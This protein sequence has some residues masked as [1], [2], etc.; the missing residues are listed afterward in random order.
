MGLFGSQR[1]IVSS[2][3]VNLGGAYDEIPGY[4]KTVLLGNII[5]PI[6]KPRAM[7]DL[8]KDA[9]L[10]GPGVKLRQFYRWAEDPLNYGQIGA[11]MA[12][13]RGVTLS[14]P[15]Q[16]FIN[17]YSKFD[18]TPVFPGFVAMEA[19]NANYF[20][21]A[22]RAALIGSQ[23]YIGG[24]PG[25]WPIPDIT[26][27]LLTGTNQIRATIVDNRLPSASTNYEGMSFTTSLSDFDPLARYLYVLYH[28]ADPGSDFSADAPRHMRIYIY[29]R[30]TGI[31]DFDARIPDAGDPVYEY[32]PTIPIRQRNVF[33]SNTNQASGK[34]IQKA[35]K[36]VFGQPV[37]NLEDRLNAHENIAEMDDVH[38]VFGVSADTTDK[39]CLEYLYRYF[40]Y[41]RYKQSGSLT[42]YNNFVTN[43]AAYR[44]A[45]TAWLA[46]NAG[47]RI[48]TA[49]TVPELPAST[50]SE[51]GIVTRSPGL[52][53]VFQQTISWRYIKEEFG[54]GL[55]K[56]T[57]KVGDL[58]FDTSGPIEQPTY[59]IRGIYNWGSGQT[60]DS[61]AVRLYWQE[62]STSWR[63][64]TLA[65]MSHRN[66]IFGSDSTY[67]T[68]REAL[69]NPN[70]SG[71]LVPLH[72]PTV[73]TMG[74]VDL[75]QM[76]AA[77]CY[78]VINSY[79]IIQPTL[80]EDLLSI[81]FFVAIVVTVIVFP[82]SGGIL[83]SNASVGAALGLTGAAAV[84]A[85][86][87][88]NA[89]AAMIV[90]K[91]IGKVSV[92]VFGDKLGALIGAIVGFVAISVGTGMANG[93]NLSEIWG[94]L[95]SAVN[96]TKFTMAVGEGIGGYVSAAIAEINADMKAFQ[97]EVD[98]KASE[99]QQL[100]AQNIGYGRGV[101]DPM[102]LTE[103]PLGNFM[104]TPSQFLT[105]TLLTG[106]DIAEVSM[107]MISEFTNATLTP[108]LPTSI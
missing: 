94:N 106:S 99:L 86:L 50:V 60:L 61:D 75:T 77:C 25:D 71:F 108:V 40:N 93:Q 67:V 102:S 88:I 73:D 26:W 18:D 11:P 69:S 53:N 85:G 8:I 101:I 41:L 56:P 14:S 74:L 47:G 13:Y 16:I 62:T 42:D 23:N 1:V 92:A 81:A 39:T 46:W 58:W 84:A 15:Y 21:W 57:A 104:E 43:E 12:Y 55:A 64:L 9:Y 79:Q 96:L 6:G 17:N 89:I 5:T 28:V 91:I 100:Y 78:L 65:G 7:G 63:A 29:K 87:V 31:P 59:L 38:V 105:R 49:P 54:T 35:F 3:T 90:T 66:Y 32:F 2:T 98:A 80:L 82:P 103:T 27:E 76:S 37:S 19:G 97:S 44:N 36:K 95:G 83:G 30:G 10:T 48:G 33:V 70:E 22:L 4:F 107:G 20:Y 45:V 68:L 51:V 34:Q 24:Y 52:N 72:R